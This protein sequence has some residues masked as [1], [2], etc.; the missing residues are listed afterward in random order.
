MTGWQLLAGPSPHAL[1]P[2]ATAAR[3]GFETA[4]EATTSAPWFAVRALAGDRALGTSP[5]VPAG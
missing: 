4:I 1:R 3:S 2:V 5:A